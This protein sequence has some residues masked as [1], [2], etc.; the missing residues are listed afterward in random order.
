MLKRILIIIASII[1]IAI[2]IAAIVLG[3][4]TRS[5][6]ASK[7][8]KYV[9]GISF[10][11]ISGSIFSTLKFSDLQ[12]EKNG[13]LF[14]AKSFDI[15]MAII[16]L[17]K[18]KDVTINS[19][20]IADAELVKTSNN[21]SN[22]NSN[23]SNNDNPKNSSANISA[24][25][26]N[27]AA[28]ITKA[29]TY[30]ENKKNPIKVSNVTIQNFSFKNGQ[31]TILRIKQANISALLHK[32]IQINLQLA[33]DL[34]FNTEST[35]D[36]SGPWNNYKI[37]Y[38]TQFN[39]GTKGTPSS[40][41]K[42]SGHGNT[43][44]ITTNF[45]INYINN[46]ATGGFNINLNN[47]LLWQLELAANKLQLPKL[48][49]P[50]LENINIKATGQGNPDTW[51][52]NANLTLVHNDNNVNASIAVTHN[53]S[54]QISIKAQHNDDH[55]DIN[56]TYNSAWK[57]N[58]DVG[59][60]NLN[61]WL[62][63][64]SGSIHTT[65]DAAIYGKLPKSTGTINAK[66]LRYKNYSADMVNGSWH[67]NPF[68]I[69]DNNLNIQAEKMA[70]HFFNAD[71]I[72][73]QLSGNLVQQNLNIKLTKDK[74]TIELATS[75]KKSDSG[76]DGLI[77]TFS[78]TNPEQPSW[79]LKQATSYT[80]TANSF[81][82]SN[83]SLIQSKTN[84][85]LYLTAALADGNW[86]AAVNS[87]NIY[88][89]N[90]LNWISPQ[91]S[92]KGDA[93]ISANISG[94]HK[95]IKQANINIIGN[96]ATI[97]IN[98]SNPYTLDGGVINLNFKPGNGL[99]AKINLTQEKYKPLIV[100]IALP[101]YNGMGLPS[102]NDTIVGNASWQSTIDT[103]TYLFPKYVRP[104]GVVTLNATL[105]GTIAKPEISGNAEMIDGSI[106]IPIYGLTLK[107]LKA[108]IS[109]KDDAAKL[110]ATALSDGQPLQIAGTLNLLP[111]SGDLTLTGNDAI[112]WNTPSYQI[113]ASPNV[114][115]KLQGK[116][117]DLTGSVLIPHGLVR[118]PNFSS[119][120]SLPGEVEFVDNTQQAV[121]N[122]SDWKVF[123]NV[124]LIIGNT[125][126]GVVLDTM[127]IKGRLTGE[128][129]ALKKPNQ[130]ILATGQLRLANK[131]Q[132]TYNFRGKTLQIANAMLTYN[133]LPIGQ[134][135][136][137]VN[138]FIVIPKAISNTG[139]HGI[140]SNLTVGIQLSGSLSNPAINFYSSPVTLNQNDIVSYIVFGQ[141][142]A[143]SGSAISLLMAAIKGNNS[144]GGIQGGLQ[145]GL[146]LGELGIE[147][148][149]TIDPLGN[150]IDHNNAVV[151][152]K[153]LSRKLYLRYSIGII[154][155]VN[156]LEVIYEINHNWSLQT[157]RSSLG[158]G[159][160]LLY[161]IERN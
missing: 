120:L 25:E 68:S 103:F 7:I 154:D 138:A 67:I 97:S 36:I 12:Y 96:K 113:Y 151:I 142:A 15:D 73:A 95:Q 71:S 41:I 76:W 82:I 49:I 109:I 54:T 21:N 152:G 5:I 131:P 55:A 107:N 87:N 119:T 11:S 35:L 129:T 157:S 98:G 23:S 118:P 18:N 44:S 148:E 81:T 128:L 33:T 28:K 132:P 64:T 137:N 158:S 134:P 122:N 42:L 58:W 62:G 99:T 89:P 133:N 147:S 91:I 136:I 69:A 26:V 108:D 126:D 159:A 117:V 145:K 144:T 1:A 9:P 153:S 140:N 160:D 84:T 75:I 51:Q 6:A 27:L 56:A 141:P 31:K 100:N 17:A 90:I 150:T 88:L 13:L 47:N 70:T 3:S 114:K 80:F 37:N 85:S 24:N 66:N 115:L 77:N 116:Q 127:G 39:Q 43:Q 16:A 10:Q 79:N 60:N 92:W 74:N 38:T 146:G 63:D 155:P 52:A 123:M 124:N 72:S 135:N 94:N 20:N 2:I 22:S 106:T 30:I 78:I 4:L 40:T 139:G 14:K 130:P 83:L 59:I 57:I 125:G 112:I 53:G 161:S 102:G 143:S 121:N 19:I 50:T 110:T 93:K 86:S 111:F 48:K 156:T 34:P 8:K 149:N 105:A 29:I 32:T 46:K 101:N 104:S 65:G 61:A 45:T